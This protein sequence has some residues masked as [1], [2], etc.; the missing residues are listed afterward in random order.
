MRESIEVG[1]DSLAEAAGA[2]I[3]GGCGISCF[4]ANITGAGWDFVAAVYDGG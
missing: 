3:C 2:F 1:L 4:P